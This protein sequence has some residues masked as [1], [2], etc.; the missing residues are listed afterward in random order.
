MPNPDNAGRS[1]RHTTAP[2][3]ASTARHVVR[4]RFSRATLRKGAMEHAAKPYAGERRERECY[5]VPVGTWI[6]D[7]D[8][9]DRACRTCN[10]SEDAHQ[11]WRPRR[12]G[13]DG[14]LRRPSKAWN[15]LASV[16]SRCAE[17]R[18]HRPSNR[19]GDGDEVTSIMGT[20]HTKALPKVADTLMLPQTMNHTAY[21]LSIGE[22]SKLL[23][24]REACPVSI[25][26]ACLARIEQLKELNAFATIVA[27]EALEH[28]RRQKR[29][30][31]QDAGAGRFTEFRLA[32]R[33][34]MT[35][36]IFERRRPSRS[37]QPT[38][39][40]PPHSRQPLRRCGS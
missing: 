7:G 28:A 24:T 31:R 38:K 2:L 33:I 21:Y 13:E 4:R 30:S 17:P 34:S 5:R 1:N 32:S 11:D 10:E 29:R 12:Q 9:G 39:Q 40:S 26:S 25:T 3:D 14:L 18:S 8:R 23:R 36:L 6:R 20:K 37:S 22:L 16:R 15:R 27:N 35:R 19:D